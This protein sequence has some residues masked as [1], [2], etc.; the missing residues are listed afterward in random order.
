MAYDIS[1]FKRKDVSQTTSTPAAPA[2]SGQTQEDSK[3]ALKNLYGLRLDNYKSDAGET[4]KKRTGV[5]NPTTVGTAEQET[6]RASDVS[7][8]MGQIAN[9]SEMAKHMKDPDTMATLQAAGFHTDSGILSDEARKHVGV[10]RGKRMNEEQ[11]IK[12]LSETEEGRDRL[13]DFLQDFKSEDDYNKFVKDTGRK[14]A[15]G[16]FEPDTM[17]EELYKMLVGNED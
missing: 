13:Q 3:P 16:L 12:Y 1:R 7:N 4:G 11:M 6:R 8:R 2:T 10:E 5:F 9:A 15:M 17:D 14:V